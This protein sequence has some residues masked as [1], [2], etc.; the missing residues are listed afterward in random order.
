MAYYIDT[1]TIKQIAKVYTEI[2]M[3]EIN[4]SQAY[5]YGSFVKGS[6]TEDSDEV[7]FLYNIGYNIHS[8]NEEENRG[9]LCGK[10]V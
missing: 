4:V 7:V 9:D 2:V 6:N 3:N 5:I 1:E 10:K 8:E